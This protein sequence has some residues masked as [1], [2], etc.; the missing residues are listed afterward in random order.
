MVITRA[1]HL[2]ALSVLAVL[3]A[4]GVTL[5]QTEPAHADTGSQTVTDGIVTMSAERDTSQVN[6]FKFTFT[7]DATDLTF[8]PDQRVSIDFT[9]YI[10]MANQSDPATEPKVSIDGGPQETLFG[11]SSPVEYTGSVEGIGLHGSMKGELIQGH[12]VTIT[13][14]CSGM[15]SYR[16]GGCNALELDI[17]ASSTHEAAS[18]TCDIDM[19][20]PNKVTTTWN[21]AD[22]AAGLR[23]EWDTYQSSLTVYADGEQITYADINVGTPAGSTNTTEVW[24]EHATIL[25]PHGE[26]AT[27]TYR[28]QSIDDYITTPASG[29]VEEGGTIVNALDVETV[30]TG[31]LE[32]TLN[33]STNG[34]HLQ[35]GVYELRNSSGDVLA[36]FTTDEDGKFLIDPT[37]SSLIA[38]MPGVDS[39][40]Q[41]TLV[42]TRAPEGYDLDTTEHQ[43]VVSL[44]E[45]LNTAT[46]VMT[47]TYVFSVDGTATASATLT[48]AH[49]VAQSQQ[50]QQQAAEH[51]VSA[52]DSGKSSTPKTSDPFAPVAAALCLAALSG[53]ALI[54]SRRIGNRED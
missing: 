51:H 14:R 31:N 8:D 29:E 12:E 43:V 44:S 25:T 1:R 54:A 4:F 38:S 46:L 16:E 10:G 2:L 36:T 48:N 34:T 28:Q 6:M 22:N 11:T 49:T 50:G 20:F 21:D 37:S 42:E 26:K 41:F 13:V 3:L 39:T 32:V 27:I 19:Q 40:V 53:A 47:H 33:D 9:P 15:T 7:I 45:D 5:A 52:T 23:P 30:T 24:C 35:G 17:P 18:C